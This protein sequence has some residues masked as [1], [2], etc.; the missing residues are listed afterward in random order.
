V[1]ANPEGGH[2]YST[3]F[4][5]SDPPHAIVEYYRNKLEADGFAVTMTNVNDVAEFVELTK[6][7][8]KIQV[9]GGI[10]RSNGGTMGTYT[11]TDK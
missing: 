4:S 8:K 7:D 10:N 6:G 3:A 9:A 11:A 5:T 1:V 2:T